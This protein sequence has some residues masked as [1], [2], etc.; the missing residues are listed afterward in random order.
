MV[1]IESRSILLLCSLDLGLGN[2]HNQELFSA[3]ME[4]VDENTL[5]LKRRASWSKNR[6]AWIYAIVIVIL[7][8]V[9][10]TV[11]YLYNIYESR[12][13]W[14]LNIFFIIL[15]FILLLKDYIN[16]KN[17]DLSYTQA[18]MFCFKTGVYFCILFIPVVLLFMAIHPQEINLVGRQETYGSDFTQL[19]MAFSVLLESITS[20]V[21]AAFKGK[22]N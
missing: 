7:V 6:F 15:G 4:D 9:Y 19:E 12:A 20:V 11:L 18:F 14:I 16:V 10:S 8:L 17:E 1:W 2:Y 13:L 3:A 22:R 21:I 5:E